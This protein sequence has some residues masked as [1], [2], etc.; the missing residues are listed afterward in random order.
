LDAT[1]VRRLE[2]GFGKPLP[3]VLQ[4]LTFQQSDDSACLVTNEEHAYVILL[5]GFQCRT[6]SHVPG[7]QKDTDSFLKVKTESIM[8]LDG[9]IGNLLCLSGH[10]R[11]V[12]HRP[13]LSDQ[14]HIPGY[15]GK[16][17]PDEYGVL[18]ADAHGRQRLRPRF[19]HKGS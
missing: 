16:R 19:E 6:A 4:H 5:L 13:H 12:A 1:I 10:C 2:H 9:H 11:P 15:R 8:T 3:A 17:H 18:Q 7:M 14:C